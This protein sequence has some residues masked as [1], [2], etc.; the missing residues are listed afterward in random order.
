MIKNYAMKNSNNGEN[1]VYFLKMIVFLIKIA[2]FATFF[3]RCCNIYQIT[4][5]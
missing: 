5:L 3:D 1:K 2:S 4:A